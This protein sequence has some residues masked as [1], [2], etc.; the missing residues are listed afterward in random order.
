MKHSSPPSRNRFASC[1]GL[2]LLLAVWLGFL[3]C[4]TGTPFVQFDEDALGRPIQGDFIRNGLIRVPV[5]INGNIQGKMLVDT[6]AP[7]SSFNNELIDAR[8]GDIVAVET[9]KVGGF[10]FLGPVIS[11]SCDFA[12]AIEGGLSNGI[13]GYDLMQGFAVTFDYQTGQLILDRRFKPDTIPHSRAASTYSMPFELSGGAFFFPFIIPPTRI[14]LDVSIEDASPI[15]M[16]F[17]TGATVTI[18]EDNF[19]GTLPDRAR[20]TLEADAQGKSGEIIETTVTRLASFQPL[21]GPTVVDMPAAIAESRL[22]EGVEPTVDAPIRGLIGGTYLRNFAVTVDYPNRRLHLEPYNELSHLDP[23]E[24]V[25]LGIAVEVQ[26]EAFVI[27]EVLEESAAETAGLMSGDVIVRVD[28]Q[29]VSGFSL[30]E[31]RDLLSVSA[32]QVVE[33]EIDRERESLT[34]SVEA[35]DRL[36][37]L[38]SL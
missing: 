15:P 28:G 38:T 34:I 3:G 12:S 17:D 31:L 23:N 9:L 8:D 10:T 5:T 25:L 20:P 36:P 24:F 7:I 19:F 11:A 2:C 27:I 1:P 32:G 18:L 33:F 22:F 30:Q 13:F 16:L 29:D 4:T 6:G 35:E 21:N 14:I 26:E 37:S